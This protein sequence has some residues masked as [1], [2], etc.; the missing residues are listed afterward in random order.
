VSN[1]SPSLS[2]RERQILQL[3]AT[4]ATNHQIA[5]EL[6]IST[7]T[8]KVHLRNIYAKLDVGSRTE[9]T[10]VAVR[11]GWVAVPRTED[12]LV[13]D[14][15]VEVAAPAERWPRVALAKR[16]ALVIAILLGFLVLFVPEVLQSREPDPITGVFPT[17]TVSSG[18]STGRWR[19]RAQMPTPRNGLAVVAHGDFVF[20]IGGVGNDGVTARVEVYDPEADAWTSRN[21][22][23][24]AV[25]FVSGVAIG[26]RI[27]VPGGI[28]A[29]QQYEKVLEVYD[30][31]SDTWEALAPMPK[32]LGAY[33]L[34][35]V[36]QQMYLFGGF[37]G[38]NYVDSVYRYDPQA[39]AWETR[40]PMRE[41]RGFLG[42]TPLGDRI[43]VLGGFNDVTEFDTCEV[44]SPAT[45]TWDSC[46]QMDARRGGLAAVSVRQS[47]YAIGGGMDSYL[48]FNE[49]Y[50]PNLDVWNRIETPVTEQ[51]RGLG[52][53]F[54]NSHIYAVG[55]WREGNLSVNEAYQALYQQ[56]IILP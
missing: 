24:T 1:E 14:S 22:K 18:V 52:A 44:Y 56:L 13:Q 46:S 25:G 32:P 54:V 15:A 2:D 8:V 43:F 35:A 21:A 27:Y 9:A 4:G 16:V 51:W 49:R 26:S 31:A 50:D 47:I 48:A 5:R 6:V 55:G 40:T 19:T 36:G 23:P 33:G 41:A 17:A 38:Q 39:N 20:A 53:A 11:Q 7:N 34:A 37:D 29:E 30:T 12:E 28:G 45:D 10:M 3:V 42:A